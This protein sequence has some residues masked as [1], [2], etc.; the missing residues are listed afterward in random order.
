MGLPLLNALVLIAIQD[1]RVNGAELQTWY[2]LRVLIV[3]S[4][5]GIINAMLLPVVHSRLF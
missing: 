1:G 4:M 3:L 2:N 5:G